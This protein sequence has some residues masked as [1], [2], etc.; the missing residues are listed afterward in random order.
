MIVVLVY[1]SDIF[2]DARGE[3]NATHNPAQHWM[4][5][6]K[7]FV[8]VKRSASGGLGHIHSIITPK[9][10]ELLQVKI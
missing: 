1:H 10:S 3:C 5:F 8:S 9:D 2:P 7:V 6:Y 4:K